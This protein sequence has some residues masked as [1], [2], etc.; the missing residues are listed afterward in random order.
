MDLWNVWTV[1]A[2]GLLIGCSVGMLLTALLTMSSRDEHRRP[3]ASHNE[4]KRL[5]V[6]AVH[7]DDAGTSHASIDDPVEPRA[8]V[9]FH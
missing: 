1:L 3:E 4:A 2:T 7:G 8:P 5:Q 6:K 9:H